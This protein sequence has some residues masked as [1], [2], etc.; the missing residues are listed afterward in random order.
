MRGEDFRSRLTPGRVS[1]DMSVKYAVDVC[2]SVFVNETEGAL[3]LE[4]M[5]PRPSSACKCVCLHMVTTGLQASLSHLH[6]AHRKC[7]GG[8]EVTSQM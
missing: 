1:W 6:S 4:L 8:S 3:T 5:P 2:V 7:D